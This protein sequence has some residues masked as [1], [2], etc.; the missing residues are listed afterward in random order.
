MK[1]KVVIYDLVFYLAIPFLVWKS[2]RDPL[3]DYYAILLSTAP[4]FCYSLYRFFVLK[5]FNFTGLFIISTL[6]ISTLID[7]LSGSA[8]RMLWNQVYYG[9]AMG[10][11]L[12]IT[13]LLKKAL[14][15][16]FAVDIS[17]LQGYQRESS[18]EFFKTKKL[19]TYLQLFTGLY[20]FKSYF[21]SGLKGYLVY[22][23][24][25]EQ[26][27]L[28]LLFLRISNW[29]FTG[30]IL[31]GLLLINKQIYDISKQT[32]AKTEGQQ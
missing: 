14:A 15:L 13:V 31:I 9:I 29:I 16:Y 7:L 19:F 17:V 30:L 18:F 3:G 23:Y 10:T 20:M 6:L 32:I 5:Q 21:N 11:F 25:V 12:L 22:K 2:G 26:Y 1:N 24:G 28:I 8:E 4:G 27:D